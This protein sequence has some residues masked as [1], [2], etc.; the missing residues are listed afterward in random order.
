MYAFLDDGPHKG[1]TLRIT[2]ER[3]GGPP[4][5]IELADPAAPESGVV[6]YVLLGPHQ[7]DEW[8]IYRRTRPGS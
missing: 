6:T 3:G 5:T 8:W 7:N 1:E 2:P 4:P